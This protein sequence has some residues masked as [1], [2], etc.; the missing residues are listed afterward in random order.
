MGGAP[1]A[2]DDDDDEDK[3]PIGGPIG[4]PI[5]ACAPTGALLAGGPMRGGAP[6]GAPTGSCA[7]W[8]FWSI[9]C[10]NF[11]KKSGGKAAGNCIS[12]DEGGGKKATPLPPELPEPLPLPPA[13]ALP[14]GLAP[15]LPRCPRPLPLPLFPFDLPPIFR[16]SL[17]LS[18]ASIL[19]Y[20]FFIVYFVISFFYCVQEFVFDTRARLTKI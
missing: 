10:Y 13:T 2:G 6:I 15:F 17:T 20:L 12:P 7:C 11:V 9:Y 1:D 18:S 19:L 8:F 3:E 5:G 16:V 4:G 14:R